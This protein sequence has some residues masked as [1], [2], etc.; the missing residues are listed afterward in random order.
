MDM[1]LGIEPLHVIERR[2][3]EKAIEMCNGNVRYAAELLDIGRTTIYRKMAEWSDGNVRQL[4]DSMTPAC[5]YP[6]LVGARNGTFKRRRFIE[7]VIELHGG[8]LTEA[9]AAMN[10]SLDRL[11]YSMGVWHRDNARLINEKARSEGISADE[12]EVMLRRRSMEEHAQRCGF[13]ITTGYKMIDEACALVGLR[14]YRHW[15]FLCKE[16]SS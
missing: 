3:I 6:A 13:T 14:R 12:I 9:A 11:V 5:D 1:R 2:H 7:R 15:L 4:T 8:N 10:Y 16:Q